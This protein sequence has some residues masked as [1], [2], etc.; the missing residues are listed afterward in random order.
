MSNIYLRYA[1]KR[2]LTFGEIDANFFN[3]NE[4]INN[5][6]LT[7]LND[8]DF[9]TL[10]DQYI[11]YWDNNDSL[12][13]FKEVES[14][15]DLQVTYEK[16]TPATITTNDVNGSIIFKQGGTGDLLNLV[17]NNDVPILKIDNENVLTHTFTNTNYSAIGTG[18]AAEFKRESGS[19]IRIGSNATGNII[20]SVNDLGGN[21][22]L[23]INPYGGDVIIGESSTISN[24]IVQISGNSEFTVQRNTVVGLSVKISTGVSGTSTIHT[25]NTL[26][27]RFTGNINTLAGTRNVISSTGGFAYNTL[28][29][30]DA[31]RIGRFHTFLSIAAGSSGSAASSENIKIQPRTLTQGTIATNLLLSPFGGNIGIGIN[32]SPTATLQIKGNSDT[33]GEAFRVENLSNTSFLSFSNAAG[34]VIQANPNNIGNQNL[35][36]I[37]NGSSAESLYQFIATGGQASYSIQSIFKKSSLIGGGNTTMG[38]TNSGGTAF[39]SISTNGGFRIV[40]N[41]TGNAPLQLTGPSFTG[42]MDIFGGRTAVS[43]N[44]SVLNATSGTLNYTG[45]F[46]GNTIN[47]TGGTGTFTGIDYNPT[48]TSILGAHYGLLIRPN[49]LNGIG[50]GSTLPTAT[51][52]IKGESDSTGNVFRAENL[53]NTSNYTLANDGTH[54]LGFSTGGKVLIAGAVGSSET[55]LEIRRTLSGSGGFSFR[56][57]NSLS[58][59]LSTTNGVFTIS[60]PDNSNINLS[61]ALGQ[62]ILNTNLRAMTGINTDF[63]VRIGN[64][65]T[66][67]TLSRCLNFGYTAA[68]GQIIQAV[69]IGNDPIGHF[70]SLNPFGGNVGIGS[71]TSPTAI[72]HVKGDSDTVGNVFSVD[73]LTNE[74]FRIQ[75]DRDILIGGGSLSAN[76]QVTINPYRAAGTANHVFRVNAQGTNNF[77]RFVNSNTNTDGGLQISRGSYGHG[78]TA[79]TIFGGATIGLSISAAGRLLF[80]AAS[81]FSASF[82]NPTIQYATGVGMYH[83]QVGTNGAFVFQNIS[84]GSANN[85][86]G[87]FVIRKTLTDAG[88]G[89]YSHTNFEIN[90]TYDL[91]N[92]VKNIIGFNYNPIITALSGSHYGLLIRPSTFNGIG[93]GSTLPT[94]TLQIKGQDTIT[95][96]SLVVQNS[97]GFQNLEIL[98]SSVS[99]ITVG[100]NNQTTVIS[101]G[102][103]GTTQ[104]IVQFLR[105]TTG[106]NIQATT[107]VTGNSTISSTINSNLTL[108]AGNLKLVTVGSNS[109]ERTNMINLSQTFSDINTNYSFSIG[110][111]RS[112]LRFGDSISGGMGNVPYLI[113]AISNNRSEAS[114]IKIN[115]FGGSVAIGVSG[116][117]QP[118]A[119]LHVKSDSDVTGAIFKA[120]SLTN[121]AFRIDSNS[122]IY[123]N[124]LHMFGTSGDIP[125]AKVDING[126]NGYNQLVLRTQYTP[127]NTADPNGFEGTITWDNDFVYVKTTVG[128]KKS[129]LITI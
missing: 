64:F 49:T 7:D 41:A 19:G 40:Q 72:L 126:A 101:G 120:E 39:F 75:N 53:S 125:Q 97:S 91:T 45:L 73:T 21:N 98:N 24:K 84:T 124:G 10:Q 78:R 30:D 56:S 70:L 127:I 5:L 16:S 36:E 44:G 4:N 104:Y 69:Q 106:V 96:S 51:L 123:S 87:M 117:L 111:N 116:S 17:R 85:T 79:L 65:P 103:S 38:L 32:T 18:Y 31:I 2:P 118:T 52:H 76:T 29:D 6:N 48:I 83:T 3:L 115:P 109:L 110:S 63:T 68:A 112:A 108:N 128:W 67:S 27:F 74:A 129:P 42:T 107:G 119:R 25:T 95:G 54:T 33:T 80:G 47:Q 26:G 57:G 60:T 77:V 113:Q 23:S 122:N 92:G 58:Q 13:K 99:K 71:T 62:V 86:G 102:G 14:G 12:F 93:L 34:L 105:G 59:I 88:A 11:M 22:L 35:F 66:N 28:T 81:A 89:S 43:I 114:S 94:A 20:Q 46:I 9:S 55:L 90:G 8:I 15:G 121:E 61:P 82:S 50:L 1:L 37:R 100:V